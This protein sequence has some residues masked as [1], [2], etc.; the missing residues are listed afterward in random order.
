MTI[1][2]PAPREP[3]VNL[4]CLLDSMH[5]QPI[6]VNGTTYL[7]TASGG[8]DN[9]PQTDADKLLVNR[10]CWRK[11]A[12]HEDTM[13]LKANGEP[14]DLTLPGEPTY[15][16]EDLVS[17]PLAPPERVSTPSLPYAPESDGE[18]IEPIAKA[19]GTLGFAPITQS[20]YDAE[21]PRKRGRPKKGPTL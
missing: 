8:L 4:S 11:V 14:A 18:R 13:P 3:R 21:I 1:H 16:A 5:G 10:D 6:T 19:S 12:S 20:Q 15:R 7:V 17:L 2:D 9:I